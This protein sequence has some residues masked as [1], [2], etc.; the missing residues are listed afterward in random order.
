MTTSELTSA[1]SEVRATGHVAVSDL[2]SAE[3]QDPKSYNMWQRRIPP[4]LR[5]EVQSH[6]KRDSARSH[7]DRDVRSGAI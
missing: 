4:Q 7:L 2:S 3:R 6:R 1:G 5:C